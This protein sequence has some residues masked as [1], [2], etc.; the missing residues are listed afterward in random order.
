VK[1]SRRC[2]EPFLVVRERRGGDLLDWAARNLSRIDEELEILATEV[3]L[4]HG[5]Q[6]ALICAGPGGEITVV[7]VLDE[8]EETLHRLGRIVSFLR[9]REEWLSGA[10]PGKKLRL[11]GE[12]RLLLL[13]AAF[14]PSLTEAIGGL[15]FGRVGMV[16]V[17]DLESSDGRSL[18]LVE[19]EGANEEECATEVQA[20]SLTPEEEEFF[21]RMEE[22]RR[23]LQSLEKTG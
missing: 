14:P 4:P 21:R 6:I 23:I 12:P 9:L 8:E 7:D 15:S 2:S 19:R 3:P 18:L 10:F 17:R 22:E 11:A 1:E 13:G 5:G 20:D 16:R